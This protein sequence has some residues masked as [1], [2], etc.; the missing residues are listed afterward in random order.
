[1]NAAVGKVP[2]GVYF[3]KNKRELR[4]YAQKHMTE[5]EVVDLERIINVIDRIPEKEYTNMADVERSVGQEL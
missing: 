5:V 1:L 4:D 2:S 3:P